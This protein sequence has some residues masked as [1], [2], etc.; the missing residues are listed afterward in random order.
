[1]AEHEHGTIYYMVMTIQN[2]KDTFEVEPRLPLP[3][4]IPDTYYVPAFKTHEEAM[5]WRGDSDLE[6]HAVAVK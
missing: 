4:V 5:E 6:I 1:M 3:L 2:F